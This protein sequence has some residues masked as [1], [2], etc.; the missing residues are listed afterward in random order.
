MDV[1]LGKPQ[2]ELSSLRVSR[3]SGIAEQVSAS[4]TQLAT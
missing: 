2:R 1:A 3:V 4:Y